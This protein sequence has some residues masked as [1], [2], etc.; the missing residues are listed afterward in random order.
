MFEYHQRAGPLDRSTSR[1]TVDG[2][3]S[4]EGSFKQHID[5]LCVLLCEWKSVCLRA[6]DAPEKIRA[7]I[8][9]IAYTAT[10]TLEGKKSNDRRA[11]KGGATRDARR[12]TRQPFPAQVATAS[13]PTTQMLHQAQIAAAQPLTVPVSLH[14]QLPDAVA[15]TPVDNKG[16]APSLT[17]A[18]ASKSRKRR[19]SASTFSEPVENPVTGNLLPQRAPSIEDT[20]EPPPAKKQKSTHVSSGFDALEFDEDEYDFSLGFGCPLTAFAQPGLSDLADPAPGFFDSLEMSPPPSFCASIASD[21]IQFDSPSP[22]SYLN[23]VRLEMPGYGDNNDDFH[24]HDSFCAGFRAGKKTSARDKTDF[25]ITANH[26]HRTFVRG[27]TAGRKRVLE[28]DLAWS[29]AFHDDI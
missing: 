22:S 7:V 14:A 4:G 15:A 2:I 12:A 13:P 16:Q 17:A 21:P 29:N 6:W 1:K 18:A 5:D 23:L 27:F 8:D 10:T 28:D 20:D 25:D 24:T 11:I 3:R 19:S 9:D 26:Y